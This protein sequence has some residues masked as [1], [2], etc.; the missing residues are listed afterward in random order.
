MELTKNLWL[1]VIAAYLSPTDLARLS[2]VCRFFHT[3]LDGSSSRLW[4]SLVREAVRPFPLDGDPQVDWKELWGIFHPHVHLLR[5]HIAIQCLA[6]AARLPQSSLEAASLFLHVHW[7]GN[8]VGAEQRMVKLPLEPADVN[9]TAD[10]V[11]LSLSFAKDLPLLSFGWNSLYSLVEVVMVNRRIPGNLKTICSFRMFHGAM[12][13][14]DGDPPR[15]FNIQGTAQDDP[16]FLLQGFVT[17]PSKSQYRALG[18][19]AFGDE[20]YFFN[21]AAARSAGMSHAESRHFSSGDVDRRLRES[22]AGIPNIAAGGL[23]DV[24]ITLPIEALA[25]EALQLP[26]D[27]MDLSSD[28][29][30]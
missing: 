7:S 27:A 30:N 13:L 19:F 28:S 3:L 14:L 12:G 24:W 2:A 9:L 16:H 22:V 17:M 25:R 8:R 15:K 23:R 6:R 1:D 11:R 4:K 18:K 26:D 5:R 21:L 10:S 29:D 20:T